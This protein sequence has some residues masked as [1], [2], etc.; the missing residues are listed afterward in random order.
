MFSE[1]SAFRSH[2]DVH[3]HSKEPLGCHLGA[4]GRPQGRS[5]GSLRL[6][7]GTKGCSK[8]L[9]ERPLGAPGRSKTMRPVHSE[10][11][12]KKL[13]LSSALG[14][15]KTQENQRKLK[16]T[17]EHQKNTQ[18]KTRKTQENPETKRKLTKKRESSKKLKPP[19]TSSKLETTREN[20]SFRKHLGPREL[21]KTRENSRRL[22]T[23]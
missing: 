14:P 5:N 8:G 12:A 21:E 10:P 16:K 11:L 2:F 7:L 9:L 23:T 6:H 13:E 17:Q 22:E 1:F 4:Q 20:S 15:E 19:A 3:G 18:T